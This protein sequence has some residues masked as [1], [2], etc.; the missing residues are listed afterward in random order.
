MITFVLLI[1]A[2]STGSLTLSRSEIF[3]P[4]RDFCNRR[5]PFAGRVLKCPYC[6]AHWVSA[7][8]TAL[9][10]DFIP[11]I[12]RFPPVN[13]FLVALAVIPFTI[14]LMILMYEGIPRLIFQDESK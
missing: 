7:L 9:S 11:V 4:L 6:T 10:W 8:F 14:P 5:V 3:T 2:V 13:V 1:L 12:S